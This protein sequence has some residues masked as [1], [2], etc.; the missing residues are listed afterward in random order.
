MREVAHCTDLL[1]RSHCRQVKTGSG[2]GEMLLFIS[3]RQKRKRV[4]ENR[5]KQQIEGRKAAEKKKTTIFKESWV[6]FCDH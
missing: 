5:K 4:G 1:L 2:I 6:P 3:R